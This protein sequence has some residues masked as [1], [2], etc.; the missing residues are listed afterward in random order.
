MNASEKADLQEFLAARP[1]LSEDWQAEDKLSHLLARLPSVPLSSNFTARVLAEAQ[2]A[3]APERTTPWFWRGW[4]PRLALGLAMV[5]VGFFS[6]HEF[7]AMEQARAARALVAASR[8]AA[9]P[10][11]DWMHNFDTIQRLDKVKVADEELL[12]VLE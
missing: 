4:R 6:F 11:I 9:L 5:G 1:Q 8:L 10:P 3:A 2:R 12:S 7:R